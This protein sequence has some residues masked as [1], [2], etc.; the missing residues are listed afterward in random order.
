MGL[1]ADNIYLKSAGI[2]WPL[3]PFIPSLKPSAALAVRY[4]RPYGRS[5]KHIYLY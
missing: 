3:Y 4:P 1:K 2:P 5:E